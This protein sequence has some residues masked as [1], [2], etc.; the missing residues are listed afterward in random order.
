MH[1]SANGPAMRAGLSSSVPSVIVNR[2]GPLEAAGRGFCDV[3][4]VASAT[5]TPL[6]I[7]V[8]A[9]EFERWTRFSNG[10]TVRLDC[11][12]DQVL[13]WWGRVWGPGTRARPQGVQ[14]ARAC[15]LK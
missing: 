10:M 13:A 8:P 14:G 2:F 4:R 11:A 6:V 7:A 15:E 12:L 3:I 1:R 5:E 9:F